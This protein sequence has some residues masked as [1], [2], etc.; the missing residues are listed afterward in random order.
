[1]T[2]EITPEARLE[3][4]KRVY[5]ELRQL[6]H[7]NPENYYTQELFKSITRQLNELKLQIK[8]AN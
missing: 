4:V 8:G 2:K 6:A 7:D 3:S 5:I 1:M